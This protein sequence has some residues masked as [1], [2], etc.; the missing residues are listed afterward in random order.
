MQM[1][2][3]YDFSVSSVIRYEGAEKTVTGHIK[4]DLIND[5]LEGLMDGEYSVPPAHVIAT[6]SGQLRQK[7]GVKRV[8]HVAAVDGGIG[9]GY[10]V[11]ESVERFVANALK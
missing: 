8:F 6:S 5:E 3:Y 1:A 9:Q 2:R 11:G 4:H 7:N 10:R